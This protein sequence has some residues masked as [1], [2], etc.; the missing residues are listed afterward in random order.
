LDSEATIKKQISAQVLV[1]EANFDKMWKVIEQRTNVTKASRDTQI[2]LVETLV[3]GR[4]GS[5]IKLIQESNPSAAFD[6]S[7]FTD[8]ANSIEAQREGFLREQ[9]KLID[10]SRRQQTMFQ[11]V[12]SGY[13]LSMGGR[14]AVDDPTI[15]SSAKTKEIMKSGRED[16]VDLDL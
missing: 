12:W 5:F 7:Q 10:L 2:K 14:S 8:L 6:Q 13:V 16:V 11:T 3:Q 1:N 15:V 9:Q 4:G